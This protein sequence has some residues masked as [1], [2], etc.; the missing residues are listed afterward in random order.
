MLSVLVAALAVAPSALAHISHRRLSGDE[1]AAWHH[2]RD[3]PISQL[4]KRSFPTDGATYPTVGSSAWTNSFPSGTSTPTSVPAAWTS[5]LAVARAQGKIPALSKVPVATMGS[6]GNPQYSTGDPN[7]ASSVCSVTY[8]CRLDSQVWDAPDGV[9]GVSFDDGPLPE[10]SPALYSFLTQNGIP[11][12]HFFIGSNI[13]YNSDEFSAAYATGGDLAVHTW[14]HPYMTTLTDSQVLAEL[15]WTMQIIHDSSGGRVPRFWRPPYGDTDARVT[16]IASAVFGL[17]TVIWNHDS[18]DWAITSASQQTT[19]ENN[20]KSWY[21]GTKSPGLVIL[22]HELRDYTVNTFMDTWSY[23]VAAGWTVKSVAELDGLNKPYQNA[24][25]PTG[26]VTSQAVV[27]GKSLRVIY[28][29]I[30]VS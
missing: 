5:A 15:G 21:Q 22:E 9:L 1:D 7:S 18:D 29:K 3:H 4:F 6:D 16:A 19:A 13:L 20:I 26:K 17:T 30:V 11:A 25:G 2:P 8:G 24:V 10:S 14:T 28:S 12:T 23:A 27:T